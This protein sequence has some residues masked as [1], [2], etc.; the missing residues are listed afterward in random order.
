MTKKPLSEQVDRRHGCLERP[1]AGGRARA[2]A[3]AA[4]RSS[5][6]RATPTA[7]DACVREIE[8]L[9]SE[10]LAVPADCSVQDEVA[11]GRRAGGRPLRP[12]RH[13]TSRTRSSR[14]TRE[15]YQLRG[16]RAAPRS[17]TSTSSG[18]C[19]A[20]GPCCR[21]CA[22]RAG[23]SCSVSSALAYRG[24]PLQGGVLR[25][26]GGAARRSSSRRASSSQKAR[27]RR[28]RLARPS[29]RDQHAA[30]RPRPPEDRLAA[31]AGAAD[32][33]AG[34][35]RGGGRSTAAS[36]RP[37]APDRLGR[38]EAP[39]G[40]EALAARRRP[41]AA[42]DRL[43][44]PAHRRAEA[45]RRAGQPLR[46]RCPATPARTAASTGSRA[47]R[48][49]GRRSRAP[50]ARLRS[51][52][53]RRSRLRCVREEQRRAGAAA[54]RRRSAESS[55]P[56]P[57]PEARCGCCWRRSPAFPGKEDAL[58][59]TAEARRTCTSRWRTA[60]RSSRASTSRSTSNEVHAIMGPNGSGKS[61][62]AYAI[63][64]HP[65]YEITEGRILFDG[66]DIT[67]ARRRR[68]RAA[69]P[70]PR[71][72]VPA[73][74]SRRHRD[75]LPAHGDQRRPQGARRRRER[76]D[77][78]PGVPQGA[79][80]ADGPPEGQPRARV[81]LPQ[82]RLLRRREE[83][84]RD[85][86]DGDAEAAHRGARRD[87]LGPRHRRAAHRRRR[88]EGARRPGD[89]RARHHALPAHPRL[90]HARTTCTSS[91]TARSSSRAAPEL[92]QEARGGRLRQ[93]DTKGV[94]V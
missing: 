43:E 72:P 19:T 15:T 94:A 28:R 92:A 11:A 38:A 90:H 4:R 16:R 8:A 93:P 82:R 88:R 18:R 68:A 76:P 60:P 77:A 34:A 84:R 21:T 62:L 35:V 91:S 85:P 86:A 33:P 22:S 37:R 13:R 53:R 49:S 83:A 46:D 25:V 14:S 29:G 20:T 7:L 47:S 48:R 10:A 32:L 58:R 42:A 70:L 67:R 73:R 59:G 2:P 41:H 30:V 87:R 36:T 50:L 89:G 31:A 23:R 5:S 55:T 65:A 63:M 54:V 39:L 75:E 69:R 78:D 1:R 6:P 40:P 81:A 45:A 61:T 17:W 79:A 56:R 64:G 52:A 74:D 27:L 71:V 12:H 44:E 51:S 66:E 57:S 24:I 3:R 26:E 9:G 80:R